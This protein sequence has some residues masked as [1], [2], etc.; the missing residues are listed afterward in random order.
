[1]HKTY[2]EYVREFDHLRDDDVMWRPY[3]DH[4]FVQMAP[5][6]FSILCMRDSA[7]WFTRKPLVF[8]IYVESYSPHRVMR[9]FGRRQLIPPQAVDVIPT[10]AH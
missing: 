9:Q 5:H 4:V 7:Y 2:A 6:G 10:A 8:D 1:M 3:S